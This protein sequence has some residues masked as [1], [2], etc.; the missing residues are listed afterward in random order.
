MGGVARGLAFGT[1]NSIQLINYLWQSKNKT[2]IKQNKMKN[3]KVR[4]NE[5]CTK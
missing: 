5:L 2:K 4:D 1:W 3:K